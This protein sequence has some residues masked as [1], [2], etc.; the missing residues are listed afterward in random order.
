MHPGC[1]TVSPYRTPSKLQLRTLQ[2]R[3]ALLSRFRRYTRASRKL[4][5]HCLFGCVLVLLSLLLSVLWLFGAGGLPRFALIHMALPPVA[6]FF[7]GRGALCALL[8]VHTP[9]D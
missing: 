8:R 5:R 3:L 7:S 9:K 1:P 6:L 4:L 2:A